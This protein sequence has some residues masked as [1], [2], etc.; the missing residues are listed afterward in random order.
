MNKKL[1]AAFLATAVAGLFLSGNVMSE[2]AP[3]TG[4]EAKV[5]CQGANACK[6]QGACKSEANA[7]AGQNGC[8]GKGWIEA[9]SK[10]ECEKAGGTVVE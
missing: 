9:T 6:G 5:K 7:C 4:G 1:T 3:T 2:E 8:K 10:E